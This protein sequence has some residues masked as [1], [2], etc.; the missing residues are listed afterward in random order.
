MEHRLIDVDRPILRI[1]NIAI[2]LQR[3]MND[4]FE[5]NKENHLSVLVQSITHTHTVIIIIIIIIIIIP[6]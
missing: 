2:H 5:L 3:D 1:P 6:G 4:K